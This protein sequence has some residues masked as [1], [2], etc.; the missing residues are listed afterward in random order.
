MKSITGTIVLTLFFLS[1][2]ATSDGTYS[3]ACIAFA[4]D[5]IELSNHRFSWDKFTDQV[6]VDENGE[7][8]DQFPEYP[9][10]GAFRVDGQRLVLTSDA[11]EEL[12]VMYLVTEGE[13]TY[14]LTSE[15]RDEQ[16]KSGNT[17]TC[18]LVKGGHR[19]DE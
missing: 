13:R 19:G 2:C 4:G 9:R 6:I 17:P 7:M 1:A 18:A 8:V 16:Q 11:R 14:L 3:P 15:Q 5:T 12:D 10:R